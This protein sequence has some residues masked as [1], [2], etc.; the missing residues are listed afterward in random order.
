MAVKTFAVGELATSADV[1]TYLTNA[2]LVYVTQVSPTP[3]TTIAVSCFSSTYDNY[4]VIVTP[5]ISASASDIRIKLRS[6]G[7]ASSVNY[8]MTNIFAS[9]GAISS[10]SE[11]GQVSWRGVYCGT[12]GSDGKYNL[13][14]FD[15]FGPFLATATRYDM[16]SSAWD[17]TSVVNR[18][19]TGFH[20]LSTSYD[21]FELSAGSNITATITVYGYRKA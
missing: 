10:T 9:A 15:L 16:R 4:K 7:T 1:N 5:V 13:L 20:D 3:A 18:S 12:G 14:T 19:A 6:G 8:Y 21:G 2:G 17:S 11:A